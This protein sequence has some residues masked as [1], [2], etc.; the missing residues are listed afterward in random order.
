MARQMRSVFLLGQ[1]KAKLLL[2]VFLVTFSVGLGGTIALAGSAYSAD[3]LYGPYSGLYYYNQ[4]GI[5]TDHNNNHAAHASTG[6][7]RRSCTGTG[8][9]TPTGWIGVLPQRRN[10]SGGLL[11]TGTW[12]YNSVPVSGMST[13]GCFINNHSTYSSQ[14]QSR[15]WN[16]SGYTTILTYLSPNQNS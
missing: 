10:S 12:A 3:A 9:N 5:H 4:A 2:G 6:A 11:C 7:Y 16:G 1:G 13:V 14:G 8:C 15:A